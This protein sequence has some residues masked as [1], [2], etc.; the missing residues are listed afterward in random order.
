[1]VR[2]PTFQQAPRLR[3]QARARRMEPV[4]AFASAEQRVRIVVRD[5]L[6]RPRLL[7]LFRPLFAIPHLVWHGLW[8]IAALFAVLAAWTATVV[9]GEV[10]GALHRFLAAYV[11]YT[12]HVWAYVCVVGRK[13]PGFV[14]RE[15]SYGLDA[16]VAGP[17]PQGRAKAA[18][19]LALAI[20]A[21]LVAAVVLALLALLGLVSWTVALVRGR[22]PARLR[23]VG[24]S[25]L[26]YG[27]QTLSYLLL[28][29]DRFPSVRR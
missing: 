9:R 21:V 15:G 14:G 11:R 12:T 28:L 6:E 27:V 2:E 18:F 23:D 10:P 25:F 3:W 24:V 26:S 22:I 19:R 29:S 13:F 17:R 16:V 1:M 5:E 20:P 8:S 4:A 7:V